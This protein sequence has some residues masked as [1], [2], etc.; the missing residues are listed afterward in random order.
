MRSAAVRAIGAALATG[1]LISC[2]PSISID[3]GIE[4][5]CIRAIAEN[6]ASR[7]PVGGIGGSIA[8]P[9]GLVP[10]VSARYL[11]RQAIIRSNDGIRHTF[12]VQSS[13]PERVL[14][15]RVISANFPPRMIVFVMSANGELIVAGQT[16]DGRTYVDDIHN[17]NVQRDFLEEVRLWSDAGCR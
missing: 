12:T 16:L 4:A 10:N 5:D 13:A 2:Q 3:T 9:L 17:N 15:M 8:H 14:L 7:G 6:A 1:A 11:G